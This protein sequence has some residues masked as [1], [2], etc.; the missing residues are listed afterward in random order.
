MMGGGVEN[1]RSELLIPFAGKTD[2]FGMDSMGDCTYL[3]S[4]SPYVESY[5]PT[6]KKSHIFF[7]CV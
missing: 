6:T 7:M 4:S 1:T 2:G 5:Y 3:W